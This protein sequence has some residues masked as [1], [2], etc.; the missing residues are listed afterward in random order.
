MLRIASGRTPGE[1]LDVGEIGLESSSIRQGD[2]QHRAPGTG[3]LLSTLTVFE[4]LQSSSPIPLHPHPAIAK[5]VPQIIIRVEGIPSSLINFPLCSTFFLL[6]AAGGTPCTTRW[7]RGFDRL[8]DDCN[9]RIEAHLL[10]LVC[11]PGQ[12]CWQALCVDNRTRVRC[13]RSL[14]T[15]GVTIS[16]ESDDR[17][18][19]EGF[20]WQ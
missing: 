18:V 15:D 4:H 13:C 10:R 8:R 1:G 2:M 12:R 7:L 16:P 20:F 3:H 11:R 5:H 9:L 19:V 17:S 6:P 14:H